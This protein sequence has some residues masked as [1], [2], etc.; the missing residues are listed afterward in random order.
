MRPD[1]KVRH[2]PVQLRCALTALLVLLSMGLL[3]SDSLTDSFSFYGALIG[4]SGISFSNTAGYLART[5]LI[6]LLFCALWMFPLRRLLKRFDAGKLPVRI[7]RAAAELLMLLA[8]YS[9]LLS[10]YL[11]M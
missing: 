8:A 4:V 1:R 9:E 7:L 2:L 5:N 6:P 3:C 11:R 10:R